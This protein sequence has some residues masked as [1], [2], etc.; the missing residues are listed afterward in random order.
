VTI[1]WGMIGCGAVA[2]VKSGPALQR[3]EGSRLVAVMRR[4]G[5]KARD[6]AGRHKVSRWYDDAAALIAD[7]EVDAVYIATPPGS[8]CDHALAVCAAGKPAYVE[9]PMARTHAE[10]RRMNAAFAAAGLPLF[11]AYY[12]RAL[13]R[14]LAVQ[15]A[16]GSGRL[17]RITGVTYRY[18]APASTALDA[19]RSA[20]RLDAE[21]SGGGLFLDVGCHTLDVLD[22]LL[23]P[24]EQVAGVAANVG[25]RYAVEDA[26]AM[27]F[28]TATG[29]PG[30]ASW[31]FAAGVYGDWIEIAGTAGHVAL[32]TFGDEPVTLTT[33]AGVQ[34]LERPNPVHVQ[35][36]LIQSIVDELHGRGRC[37]STGITAARTSA[38]MDAVLVGYYGTRDDDFWRDAARWPGPRR[39][40][41]G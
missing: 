1:G 21:H 3:A 31:N 29:A 9:K 33:A 30:T 34:A 25:H 6:Y 13:P 28:V 11:V 37:P 17:G 24:L 40:S 39:P 23:G 10:C 18:A 41:R 38:V 19:D 2:E 22:F 15:E 8:H 7:P 26:V 14:F 32:S 12:R 4:D 36:P 35:Q 16:I 27:S 20:W 5:G